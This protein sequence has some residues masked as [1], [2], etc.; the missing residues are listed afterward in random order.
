M[1]LALFVLSSFVYGG[2]YS[3]DF[4]S[5]SALDLPEIIWNLKCH[6]NIVGK[7]LNNTKVSR[8]AKYKMVMILNR[9]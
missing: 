5:L 1:S 7:L 3:S 6:N 9:Y 8:N 4:F 2:S